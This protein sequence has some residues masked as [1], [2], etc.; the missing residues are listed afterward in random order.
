MKYTEEK[1]EERKKLK[2]GFVS[3]SVAALL[4]IGSASYFAVENYRSGI[5]ETDKKPS[6]EQ[7]Y[8]DNDSSYTENEPDEFISYDAEEEVDDVP[9]EQETQTETEKVPASS[10][11]MP[12][13]GEVLK[14][15]SLSELQ[16]S[17]TMFD[18]R[19][20]TGVDIACKEGSNI[21]SMSD[22]TVLYVDDTADYGKTVTIKHSDEI[23]IKYAAFKTVKVKQGDTVKMGDILGTSGT[24]PIECKD[25]AHIH[26]ELTK[27]GV[28]CD[29]LEELG[30]K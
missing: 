24:A 27:N 12:V 1:L 15:F 13:E 22:G 30:L 3:V 6:D 18:M 28:P 21:H 7:S 8:Q 5:P 25:E 10:Y 2:K 16:Y 19:L 29:A 20:H 9:Y 23:T 17:K 11:S 14:K 26:I 4:I